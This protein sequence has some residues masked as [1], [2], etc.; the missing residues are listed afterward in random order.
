MY[1]NKVKTGNMICGYT[2]VL[3]SYLKFLNSGVVGNYP[4]LGGEPVELV[5]TKLGEQF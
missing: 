3:C 4:L 2:R 1:I 5:G